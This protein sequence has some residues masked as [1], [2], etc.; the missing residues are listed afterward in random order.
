MML[1]TKLRVNIEIHS[2]I[3]KNRHPLNMRVKIENV[4]NKQ[5][6]A[7]INNHELIRLNIQN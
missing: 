6:E 1:K 3:L 4:K 5:K 2:F 7:L